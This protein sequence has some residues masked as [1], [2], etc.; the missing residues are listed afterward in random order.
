MGPERI[1]H[2]VS[3][4]ITMWCNFLLLFGTLN[5]QHVSSQQFIRNFEILHDS[6]PIDLE[7]G[8]NAAGMQPLNV[9]CVCL[10]VPED[11]E[12]VVLVEMLGVSPQGLANFRGYALQGRLWACSR[13][14]STETRDGVIRYEG[15]PVTRI[16]LRRIAATKHR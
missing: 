16:T 3:S 9:H 10:R 4:S 13:L 1:S 15:H 8:H 5:A 12:G 6:L 14:E 7:Y 11:V 2:T